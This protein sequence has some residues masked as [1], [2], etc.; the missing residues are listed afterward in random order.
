LPSS[1]ALF[2][3]L[4][5]FRSL[6]EVSFY[7]FLSFFFSL[8]LHYVGVVNALI[9]GEIEDHVWF[10]DWWMVASLCDE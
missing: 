3:P 10:K 5:G 6:V 4:F 2:L 8:L 9:K 1:S 7:S